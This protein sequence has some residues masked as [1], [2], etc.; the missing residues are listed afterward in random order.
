MV[1]WK[2]KKSKQLLTSVQ[3]GG[4]NEMLVELAI[5]QAALRD[6]TTLEVAVF[7]VYEAQ[8]VRIC[9]LL[10]LLLLRFDVFGGGG[11]GVERVTQ[12]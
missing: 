6:K 7:V 3:T 1:R 12:W 9:R 8:Q 2:W 10:C 5:W 11:E 4:E